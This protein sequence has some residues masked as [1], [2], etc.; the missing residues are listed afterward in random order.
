MLA[1]NMMACSTY[2]GNI[3][4]IDQAIV[5][6]IK[7][8]TTT[9]DEVHRL[10]GQSTNMAKQNALEI[11]TYSYTQANIAAKAYIPFAN[12]ADEPPV[13]LTPSNLIIA[14]NKSGIVEN[15]ASSTNE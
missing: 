15:V 1:S 13:V 9:K 3:Q 5:D 2:F 12:L 10:L 4:A 14:F 7:T 6:N 8:G 11:W